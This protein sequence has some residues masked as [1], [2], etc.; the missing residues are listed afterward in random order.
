MINHIYSNFSWF[1]EQTIFHA[2]VF[3]LQMVPE[4]RLCEFELDKAKK[5][6]SPIISRYDVENLSSSVNF[7]LRH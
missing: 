6:F 4:P 3:A 5:I 2:S 7:S 1:I